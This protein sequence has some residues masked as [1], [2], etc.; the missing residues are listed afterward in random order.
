MKNQ[1]PCKNCNKDIPL[2]AIYCPYCGV[3]NL[4]LNANNYNQYIHKAVDAYKGDKKFFNDIKLNK[5]DIDQQK[6]I[7]FGNLPGLSGFGRI[8]VI[9]DTIY[10]HYKLF[11]IT[12][13]EETLLGNSAEIQGGILSSLTPVYDGLFFN[14]LSGN[15]LYRFGL[16]RDLTVKSTR[17]TFSPESVKVN[18]TYPLLILKNGKRVLY[19]TANQK[20]FKIK[21]DKF[22]NESCSSFPLTPLKPDEYWL[23]IIPG[24][25]GQTF[26]LISSFGKIYSITDSNS[27]DEE[28][29]LLINEIHDYNF[30]EVGIPIV[31]NN[32]IIFWGRRENDNNLYLGVYKLAER[33]VVDP[34]ISI[35]LT[36]FTLTNI[37]HKPIFSDWRIYLFDEISK[38]KALSIDT[39]GDIQYSNFSKSLNL[40]NFI[41]ANNK[42]YSFSRNQI[43][44]FDLPTAKH[45]GDLP[46]SVRINESTHPLS[47]MVYLDGVIVLL[48]QNNVYL[49]NVS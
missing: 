8:L 5:I 14:S 45:L 33:I 30:S 23:P 15:N 48:T 49:N 38:T 7:H 11:D 18:N 43:S 37:K 6:N 21:L 34:P 4:H 26:F 10:N 22:E 46:I 44:Y 39:D 25:E 17:F 13:S 27:S 1:F 24:A 3:Q 32:S 35:N 12:G 28:V 2:Q 42:I 41:L 19:F 29:N 9:P 16:N 20:L 40:D 31:L 47:P 36:R